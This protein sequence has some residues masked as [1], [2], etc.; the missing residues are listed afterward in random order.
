T[1]EDVTARA[2]L[3]T[4][5]GNA[6]GVIAA[7]LDGDHW[8][9]L[10]VANDSTANQ[11]WINGHDSTF[12]DQALLGGSALS[13]EGKAQ[14]SMGVDAADFDADGDVDLFMTHLNNETNTLY[15]NRGDGLFEDRGLELGLSSP[16]LPYTAFGTRWFDYDND[17]WLDLVVIDGEVKKIWAQDA[18][19]DPLPLKQPGQL[20]HNLGDGRYE[21]AT[22]QAGPAL[23]DPVVGRAAALGDVDDDGDLDLVV[24]VNNG[25]VRLLLN[26]AAAG[27]RW[28]GVAL[29]D[30]AGLRVTREAAVAVDLA[31]G[32]SLWR[33][34]QTDGSYLAVHDPRVLFGL[35]ADPKLE[36]VRVVWPDGT[37][38]RF[39]PPPLDAYS[40]LHR[41][42]GSLVA[43]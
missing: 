17:G 34:V 33:R 20:F 19:G 35:G 21:E 13:R 24:T 39:A 3:G 43:P 11:M 2:G 41:G 42:G 6:L 37:T 23:T 14:A 27:N 38:E 7:D 4:A 16:S 30:E 28:L 36:A 9:D 8:T 40:T 25:P 15:L 29:V 10:Y 31:G 22:A 26:Q 1:F 5:W 32:R 18:A 12:T